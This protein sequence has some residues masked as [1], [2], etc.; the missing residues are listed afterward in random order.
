MIGRHGAKAPNTYFFIPA[1]KVQGNK[2]ITLLNTLVLPK[3][4][5]LSIIL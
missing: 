3:K 5:D 4:F 2:N 1:L